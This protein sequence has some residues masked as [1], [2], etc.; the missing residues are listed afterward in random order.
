MNNSLDPA[1]MWQ[2]WTT[3]AGALIT[4]RDRLAELEVVVPP[5]VDKLVAAL[6]PSHATVDMVAERLLRLHVYEAVLG[7]ASSLPEQRVQL[8]QMSAATRNGLDDRKLPSEKLTGLQLHH[9]GAFYKRSWRAND[10][11]WG[12][13]DGAGWLVH[14]LLNPRRLVDVRRLSGLD[15]AE[16]RH[17]LM[18]ELEAVACGEGE[19]V[20][21][22]LHPLWAAARTVV[23]AELTQLDD[24]DALPRS[25]PDT[26][27]AV[28]RGVQ[29]GILLAELPSLRRQIDI[30]MGLG[31]SGRRSLAF[32]S[33]YDA[34][35]R[36]AELSPQNALDLLRICD[37]PAETLDDEVGS[38]LLTYVVST[39]AATGMAA[40]GGL[41]KKLPGPLKPALRVAQLGTLWLYFLTRAALQRS[42]TSFAL[43]VLMVAV[44]AV[45]LATGPSGRWRDVSLAV[46]IAALLYVTVRLPKSVRQGLRV[47]LVAAPLA[48]LAWMVFA[49][50]RLP[51]RTG[52]RDWPTR[53]ASTLSADGARGLKYS[54]AAIAVLVICWVGFNWLAGW[55]HPVQG[56]RGVRRW[57]LYR[58]AVANRMHTALER[59]R[60]RTSLA[61]ARLQGRPL[62]NAAA[63]DDHAARTL[64][65]LVGDLQQRGAKLALASLDEPRYDILIPSPRGEPMLHGLTLEPTRVIIDLTVVPGRQVLLADL[66][67]VLGEAPT[68]SGDRL[69]IGLDQLENP[70][71]RTDVVEVLLNGQ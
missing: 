51:S 48:L 36:T 24:P 22:A 61:T 26:A 54:V 57:R 31:A 9:F 27:I 41:L 1:D 23:E 14:V 29:L 35:T 65:V 40:A 7:G 3:L 50:S 6:V 37:V 69:V 52:L 56:A 45:V 20:Q 63:R 21:A 30:D 13:L 5:A 42:R 4:A 64:A 28:A 44:P 17:R 25:L 49:P 67:R 18:A 2:R 62:D 66:G 19:D 60:L 55:R 46:L 58:M 34:R 59:A 33:E 39:A 53:L 68:T 47:F 71:V 12:R 32:R 70:R 15:N 16:F 43:L 38:D 8:I 11:M 10:W